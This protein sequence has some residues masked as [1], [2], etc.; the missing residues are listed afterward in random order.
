[1]IFTFK[2]M[3]TEYRHFDLDDNNYY[4]DVVDAMWPHRGHFYLLIL[5]MKKKTL[6][7]GARPEGL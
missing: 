2:K 3:P 4:V 1:M 6:F 5:C 7:D